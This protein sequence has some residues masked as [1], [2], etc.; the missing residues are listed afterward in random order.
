MQYMIFYWTKKVLKD[1]FEKSWQSNEI[2]ATKQI[3]VLLSMFPEF[4]NYIVV[5]YENIFDPGK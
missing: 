3:K 2:W 1:I 4:E 5:M